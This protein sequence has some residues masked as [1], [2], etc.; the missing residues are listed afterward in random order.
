MFTY[1]LFLC[2][3]TLNAQ[4]ENG[5]TPLHLAI[6]NN[7]PEFVKVLLQNGAGT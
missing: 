5:E 6:E 3:S 2:V 4:D 1:H 7:D